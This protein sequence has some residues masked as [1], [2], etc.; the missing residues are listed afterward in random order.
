MHRESQDRREG[1]TL[2]TAPGRPVPQGQARHQNFLV[3]PALCFLPCSLTLPTQNSQ[4]ARYPIWGVSK[5]V[6]FDLGPGRIGF[7]LRSVF[8]LGRQRL[9]ALE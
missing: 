3:L 4:S 2:L 5:C 8:A 1:K 6:E 7:S 9:L